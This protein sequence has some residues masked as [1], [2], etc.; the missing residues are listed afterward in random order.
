MII[1]T[2]RPERNQKNNQGL[3]SNWL[4]ARHPILFELHRRDLF[5]YQV[6]QVSSTQV[7][8]RA[9]YDPVAFA[10]VVPGDFIYFESNINSQT[11]IAANYGVSAEIVSIAV[12]NGRY[13]IVV[14]YPPEALITYG[15]FVNVGRLNHYVVATI[16]VYN[17]AT[18]K[19][20][21]VLA[22]LKGG[23]DGRMR[24]DCSEFISDILTKE[25]LT[26]PS[27]VNFRDD[28]VWCRFYISL[29]ERYTGYSGPENVDTTTYYAVDAV[30]DL[31]S[32]YGQNMCDYLP[33]GVAYTPQAKFLT[34][35]D[36]PTYFPGYPF[37]LSFIYPPDVPSSITR[38]EDEFTLS[39]SALSNVSTAIDNSKQGGVNRLRLSGTYSS[40][41]A[42]LDVYLMA[43]SA[44]QLGY[45]N[46]NYIADNYFEL[47]PPTPPSFTPY[48]LTEKKRVKIGTLCT[49]NP[50][51][52]RWRNSK[53]G[54]DYWLFKSN[55]TISYASKQEGDISREPDDLQDQN[56]RSL[57]LIARQGKRIT[58]GANVL[59]EDLE[60][61][62]GVEASI[63]VEM[64][65]GTSP[66]KWLRMKVVPKGFSYQTK[67][68]TA[69]VVVDL[70]YP[71]PYSIP[72]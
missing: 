50:V 12:V 56:Y 64:L 55:Q 62:K 16:Y 8:V 35:F 17:P 19:T 48:Q 66:V 18:N 72:A 54:F 10:G 41:T 6:A 67:G 32:D 58:C 47:D 69:D 28:S 38:E 59:K 31:L 37:E 40:G 20:V 61:I 15:G 60:G 24:L 36:K 46:D 13:D 9:Q 39:G 57:I 63:F 53:G 11:N 44:P 4:C 34:A 27:G 22:K 70:E 52:I 42:Q 45:Y 43:D 30:K 25:E 51:Y 2:K 49:S 26:T 33:F 68:T 3:Q 21:P 1:F 7:V 71:E 14:N 29:A 23:I 65:I 5:I